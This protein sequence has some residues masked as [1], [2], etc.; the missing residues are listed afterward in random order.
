MTARV[1]GRS[2]DELRPIKI[3]PGFLA[4]AEGSALI[5]FGRTRVVCTASVEERVPP[6]LKGSGQGWITGEYAMIPRSTMTRTPRETGRGP[7][8]R[9]HEIQR[10]IGRSLRAIA[11]LRALG[12]RTIWVDCDVLEADGGTRTASITGGYVALAQALDKLR[13]K[14]LFEEIPIHQ[15]LAAVSVGLVDGRALLDLCYEEDLK[16]DVDMNVVM[17]GDG[18][19]VEVQGTG[20]EATFSRDELD[21][22]LNLAQIGTTTLISLQRDALGEKNLP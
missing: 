3:E 2:P 4:H 22:L 11:N 7:S 15:P 1:D 17:T 5:S 10:L 21:Q 12:E 13:R 20:E 16:A 19:F 6:F 8:G 18:K 9:T 14:G